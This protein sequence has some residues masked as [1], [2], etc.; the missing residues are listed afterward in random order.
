MD[1]TLKGEL[2]QQEGL[3]PVQGFGTIPQEVEG[4]GMKLGASGEP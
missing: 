2:I 4:R 1:T 3:Q